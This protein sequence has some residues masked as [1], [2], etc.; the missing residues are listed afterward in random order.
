[1]RT[2]NLALLCVLF[3]CGDDPPTQPVDPPPTPGGSSPATLTYDGPPL[4]AELEVMES[5]PPQYAVRVA[6]TP[7]TSGFELEHDETLSERG[8]TT[9]HFK[10][11]TPA[12]DEGN[13][14]NRDPVVAR[15]TL[16]EAPGDV[17]HVRVATWERGV[18]YLRP[19]TY[20]LAAVVRR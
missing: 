3:A 2:T 17:V 1:M 12:E 4:R 19:P 16:D 13:S 7:P 9:L 8:V 14:A 20:E 10:L 6:V 5:Q 11:T 18:Q 15:V